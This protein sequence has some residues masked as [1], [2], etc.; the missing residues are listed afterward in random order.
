MFTS[1]PA[2]GTAETN[3]PVSQPA[4]Q[5]PTQ[6]TNVFSD[7]LKSIVNENGEQK[8]TSVD[9]ALKGLSHSQQY[10]PQ[11][12]SQL[13]E[14]DAELATLREELSKRQSVEDVVSRLTAQK[15]EASEPIAAPQQPVDNSLNEEAVLNIVAQY[16]QQQQAASVAVNNQKLVSDTLEQKFGTKAGEV[17]AAKASELGLTPERIGQI[18]SESPA[19]ALAMFG[20]T[21]VDTKPVNTGTTFSGGQRSLGETKREAPKAPSG[22]RHTTTADWVNYIS[23]MREEIVNRNK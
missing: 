5:E 14:K 12:Q 4:N 10:I 9:E 20:Q 21:S 16:S 18:A 17:V 11:L 23:Q 15:Q 19:A 6:N 2:E 3:T 8:Y 1:Q 13:S 7:Q 22:Q